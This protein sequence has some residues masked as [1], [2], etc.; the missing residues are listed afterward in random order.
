MVRNATLGAWIGL[1]VIAADNDAWR[2]SYLQLSWHV[3]RHS[4]HAVAGGLGLQ[5]QMTTRRRLTRLLFKACSGTYFI[6]VFVL[7]ACFYTNTNAVLFKKGVFCSSGY[8]TFLM[9]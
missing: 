2:D 9:F 4:V 1:F 8:P 5:S 6:A 3:I 7:E